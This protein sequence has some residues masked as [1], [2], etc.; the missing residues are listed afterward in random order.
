MTVRMLIAFSII[1][2][3]IVGCEDAKKSFNASFKKSFN[4]SFQKRCIENAIKGG[5]KESDAKKKCGCVAAFLVEN[6]S[7]VELIKLSRNS[8]E[9]N[10]ILEEA[11][12]SC[13]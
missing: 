9:S 11:I 3:I 12:N 4:E 1:L 7:F 5:V 10:E 6:Y 8:P 2:T 13:N